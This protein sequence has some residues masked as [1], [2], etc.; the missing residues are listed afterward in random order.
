MNASAM[1]FQKAAVSAAFFGTFIEWYD[2]VIAGIAASTVWPVVFFSAF[3][4]IISL[5]LLLFSYTAMYFSRPLA[6][7]IFGH[8]GDK[9]GRKSS[10]I[11]TLLTVG[12]AMFSIAALPPYS[13]IGIAAPAL[14]IAFRFLQGFGIG[15]EWQGAISWVYE[16][17]KERKGFWTSLMQAA[18][19][20]GFGLGPLVFLLIKL[21]MTGKAFLELGWR[22]P[23]VIGG[24]VVVAGVV[25]RL[26][27]IESPE[28]QALKLS[29][30]VLRTPS[31]YVWKGFYKYITL[32]VLISAFPT[33]TANLLLNPLG[34]SYMRELGIPYPVMLLSAVLA[35]FLGFPFVILGGLLYDR[36]K[37][38]DLP[39]ALGGAGVA[40]M[41]YLYFPLL[42][43]RRSILIVLSAV[44]VFAFLYI[45]FGALGVALSEMFP[46]NV[47]YSGVGWTLQIATLIT[48]LILSF[49]VPLLVGASR[50][51]LS[52]WPYIS[53][54]VFMLS[55][56][57]II[58]A[59]AFLRRD[60]IGFSGPVSAPK[61]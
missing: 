56:L 19:P 33:A 10:L 47:R 24:L 39:I 18:N 50:G 59:L 14:L 16:S 3:P 11:I 52:A 60:A 6:A 26:R 58:A 8:L 35:G 51:L 42:R 45:A 28:F 17:A 36:L 43:T 12:V 7:L 37:R 49:G 30:K 25:L 34:L 46:V 5:V 20:I 21:S 23:F 31:L 54:I 44:V 41:S 61:S 53:T 2:V 22:I 48:G 38:V 9:V 15:G 4:P 29:G 40:I 32:G 27:M 1:N 13:E 57:G 55:L